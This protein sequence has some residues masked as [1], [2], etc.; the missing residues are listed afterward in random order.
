M[1]LKA[2]RVKNAYLRLIQG[3]QHYENYPTFYRCNTPRVVRSQTTAFS[4]TDCWSWNR[5]GQLDAYA[6]RVLRPLFHTL[7]RLELACGLPGS[8]FVVRL[9]R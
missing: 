4:R 6:P 7:D 2:M 3:T 5:V 1:L 8:I 9:V